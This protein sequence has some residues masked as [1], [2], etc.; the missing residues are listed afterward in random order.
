MIVS[1]CLKLKIFR[2]HNNNGD[3]VIHFLRKHLEVGIITEFKFV[4]KFLHAAC[5]NCHNM[6]WL[7]LTK[8]LYSQSEED[9]H[10]K[11][12]SLWNLDEHDDHY[13]MFCILRSIVFKQFRKSVGLCQT[14]YMYC[15]DIMIKLLHGQEQ[16]SV[17]LNQHL[18]KNHKAVW[19]KEWCLSTRWLC[20]WWWRCENR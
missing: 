20:E 6:K 13:F 8:G 16:F 10:D 2:F 7:K 15:R 1:K 5:E 12:D 17:F 9:E 19:F 14:L 4:K 11:Q 18:T 3:F